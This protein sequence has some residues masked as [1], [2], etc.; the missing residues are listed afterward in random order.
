MSGSEQTTISYLTLPKNDNV[1]VKIHDLHIQSLLS[2]MK[3]FTGFLLSFYSLSIVLGIWVM[4]STGGGSVALAAVG[5]LISMMGVATGLL[6]L[7]ALY[8]QSRKSSLRFYLVLRIFSVV[9][10]VYLLSV[11][12]ALG[13]GLAVYRVSD[14]V[15]MSVSWM[16]VAVI[17]LMATLKSKELHQILVSIIK[18][19]IDNSAV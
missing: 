18:A 5:T 3:L 13:S 15:W 19:R 11:Y 8:Y 16:I 6:G 2:S 12:A 1:L 10:I 9:W 17:F 4:A 7:R 14:F